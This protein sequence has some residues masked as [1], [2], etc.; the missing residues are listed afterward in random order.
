MS[1]ESLSR[2]TALAIA[3]W[4]G[5]VGG[6]YAKDYCTG[7][8]EVNGTLITQ[9]CWSDDERNEFYFTSQGSQLMPYAWLLELERENSGDRFFTKSEGLGRFGYLQDPAGETDRNPDE[10]P[11]GFVKDK[12]PDGDDGGCEFVGMTCAACHT[13]QFQRAKAGGSPHVLLVDGAPTSAD[14]YDF[15]DELS[16]AL[17]HTAQDGAKL[18]AFAARLPKDQQNGGACQKDSTLQAAL[19]AKS[20]ELAELLAPPGRPK[21]PEWGP[22]RLDAVGIII[23]QIVTHLRLGGKQDDAWRKNLGP[24]DAPVSYPFI[25]DA[26]QH[27]QVQWNGVAR[28]PLVRNTVE[29]MGVFAD[30]GPDTKNVWPFDYYESSIRFEGMYT[31]EDRVQTLRSPVWPAEFFDS[32]VSDPLAEKGKKI[33]VDSGCAKCH[34][35]VP[36]DKAVPDIEARMSMLGGVN[37]DRAMAVNFAERTFVDPTE[38]VLEAGTEAADC[39]DEEP[40]TPQAEAILVKVVP[41]IFWKSFKAVI[42]T[43]L[44]SLHGVFLMPGV[45]SNRCAYK[46]RPLDGIW[47]TAPYLHNG[48]VPNLA[49]LMKPAAERSSKFCVSQIQSIDPAVDTFDPAKV[50][51]PSRNVCKPGEFG[52]DTSL[53]GNSNVGHEYFFRAEGNR[54]FTADEIKAL[55]EYQKSL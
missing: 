17:A 21:A 41:R 34:A 5:A 19:T 20:H 43:A 50:G 12:Q 25:W 35:S 29:V 23:N 47:A 1:H 36:R 48:S 10:L 27:N 9:Q 6:V 13:T 7:T 37:T 3:G 22:A 49:E 40:A 26:H 15:I 31:L 53:P 11:I 46:G 54:P 42:V 16:R 4:L 44:E 51:L 18:A 28:T 39:S 14:M 32:P 38:K 2:V 30:F 33:F 45:T 8:V 24:V 55:V 52:F